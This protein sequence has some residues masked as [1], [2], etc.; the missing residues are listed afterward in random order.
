MLLFVEATAFGFLLPVLEK[1]RVAVFHLG[2]HGQ[3][4]FDMREIDDSI[5]CVNYCV[6]V[7]HEVPPFYRKRL[8]RED[9]KS[10]RECVCSYIELDISCGYWW[11]QL[12]ICK[13][14]WGYSFI[15]AI[16]AVHFDYVV[17][18]QKHC[19]DERS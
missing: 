17:I 9:N 14:G 13:G 2:C 4:H 19:A 18:G 11:F 3:R 8:L 16:V 10:V 6:M 12:G 7:A 5:C 15:N 1:F